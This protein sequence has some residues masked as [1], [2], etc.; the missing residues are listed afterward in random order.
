MT[1]MKSLKI[2]GI[3]HY[4]H[5]LNGQKILTILLMES[6]SYL[7]GLSLKSNSLKNAYMAALFGSLTP[8]VSYVEEKM[9]AIFMKPKLSSNR[10]TFLSNLMIKS[11]IC[12]S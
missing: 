11:T 1:H 6:K 4:D 2:R 3:S 10:Q 9:S 12:I 5:Q 7:L 8:R